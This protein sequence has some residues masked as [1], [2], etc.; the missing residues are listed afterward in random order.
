[1]SRQWFSAVSCDFQLLL[2]GATLVEANEVARHADVRRTIK[3]THIRSENQVHAL[4]G[5]P[6]P[7]ATADPNGLLYGFIPGGATG[8]GLSHGDT[9][10]SEVARPINEQS[11][12][13]A[14]LASSVV[15]NRHQ[16]TACNEVEAAGIAPAYRLMQ[17]IYQDYFATNAP[18]SCRNCVGTAW[19][20]ASCS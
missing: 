4:V 18:T 10:A 2:R 16:M 3:H 11:P 12:A 13:G 5:V 8:Q 1:M 6:I 19:H 9:A 20:S 7:F 14:G 15:T 17:V